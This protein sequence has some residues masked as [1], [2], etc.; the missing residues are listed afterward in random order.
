MLCMCRS[1]YIWHA[2][3]MSCVAIFR[4]RLIPHADNASGV[5]RCGLLLLHI[6]LLLIE[7]A[8]IPDCAQ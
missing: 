7:V 1:T 2:D 4:P 8:S 6:V 3:I 5:C